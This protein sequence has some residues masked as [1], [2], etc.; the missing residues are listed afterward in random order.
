MMRIAMMG[1][2]LAAS[3]VC[4]LLADVC[5]MAESFRIIHNQPFPPFSELKNGKSEGLSIDILRA[6]AGRVG[7]DLEFVASPIE[8]M[9]QTLK[10]GRGDALLGA[11]TPERAKSYDFST[12]VLMS[13]G[14]LFVRTPNP[15][16]ESLAALS[17]KVVVTPGTGPVAAIIRQSA[18]AVNLSV[19][20]DYEQSLARVVDGTADAAALNFQAGAIIAIR[21][22][23]GRITIPQRMFQEVANAVSVPK[24]RHTELIARLS[25]GLDSIRADG[26]WKEINTR[27][28]GQ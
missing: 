16:P 21:L 11:V 20:T 18:P 8:Q 7:I 28:I 25:R 17:G 23:P 5:G 10:D 12:P 24:G 3:L 13:G 9:E 19:T 22:Y 15:T 14:G 2:T 26:T 6:A 27:W 1:R 4:L